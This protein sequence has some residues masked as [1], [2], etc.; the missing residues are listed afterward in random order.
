MVKLLRGEISG[1]YTLNPLINRVLRE[2]PGEW[3]Q[4]EHIVTGDE[5][6]EETTKEGKG[7]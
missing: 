5:R 3:E 1:G 7:D 6:S 2:V 4:E